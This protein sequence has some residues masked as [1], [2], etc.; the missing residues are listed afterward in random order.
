[1]NGIIWKLKIFII[2][3]MSLNSIYSKLLCFQQLIA[4]SQ[5]YVTLLTRRL[6]FKGLFAHVNCRQQM[7]EWIK[8]IINKIYRL[9]SLREISLDKFY[10]QII[11]IGQRRVYN[12]ILKAYWKKD[13]IFRSHERMVTL[14]G[15]GCHLFALLSIVCF[16]DTRM[17]PWPDVIFAGPIFHNRHHNC[18]SFP[19]F[20]QISSFVESRSKVCPFNGIRAKN[21]NT[22]FI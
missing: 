15:D 4:L 19:V 11:G 14:K 22:F 18:N 21:P 6:V 5:L 16:S 13:A 7:N 3:S 17:S 20:C 12:M 2:F 8:R 1:M 10:S 9:I